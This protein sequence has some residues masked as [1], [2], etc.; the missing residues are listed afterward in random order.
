MS[1]LAAVSEHIIIVIIIIIIIS[2]L[3]SVINRCS[4]LMA[5]I[6]LASQLNEA[7]LK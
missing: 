1:L 6:A 5:A 7:E 4:S 2:E 3:P